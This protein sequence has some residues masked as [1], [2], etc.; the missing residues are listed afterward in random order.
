M[1]SRLNLP[2]SRDWAFDVMAKSPLTIRKTLLILT[3]LLFLLAQAPIPS[4]RQGVERGQPD[5]GSVRGLEQ[6]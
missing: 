4:R 1:R 3:G 6:A 2:R 5:V